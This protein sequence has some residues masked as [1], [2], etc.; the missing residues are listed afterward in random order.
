MRSPRQDMMKADRYPSPL[1]SAGLASLHLGN[2]G[3]AP[4]GLVLG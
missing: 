3:A 4:G 1:P 2:D